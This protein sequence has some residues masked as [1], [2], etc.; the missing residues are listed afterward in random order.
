M[1][2]ASLGVVIGFAAVLL[3][4]RRRYAYQ[5]CA[6]TPA[7]IG[8]AAAEAEG[9]ATPKT[10]RKS[11]RRRMRMSRERLFARVLPKKYRKEFAK[12]E[13]TKAKDWRLMAAAEDATPPAMRGFYE[14]LKK[15][16]TRRRQSMRNMKLHYNTLETLPEEQDPEAQDAV[17]NASGHPASEQQP[18]SVPS[19]ANGPLPEVGGPQADGVHAGGQWG[20][21]LGV[22]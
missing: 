21:Y 6:P 8:P 1:T 5:R 13:L 19:V 18:V 3:V 14:D 12:V 22:I 4:R 20:G 17:P 10:R 16:R 7:R 15:A 11:L 9:E 2:A